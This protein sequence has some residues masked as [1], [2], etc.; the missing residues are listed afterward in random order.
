MVIFTSILATVYKIGNTRV[1]LLL[2]TLGMHTNTCALQLITQS[3]VN[4]AGTPPQPTKKKKSFLHNLARNFPRACLAAPSRQR[5]CSGNHGRA[6]GKEVRR[7]K[8]PALP[9]QPPLISARDKIP[10]ERELGSGQAQLLLSAWVGEESLGTIKQLE[11]KSLKFL[12]KSFAWEPAQ[13]SCG[14]REMPSPTPSA[15]AALGSCPPETTLVSQDTYT[16]RE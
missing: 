6:A 7:G 16:C 5:Q 8:A 1:S 14:S 12:Q 2:I 9:P 15:R 11:S 4:F 3:S 13:R 10:G